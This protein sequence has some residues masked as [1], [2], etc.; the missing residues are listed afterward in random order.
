MIQQYQNQLTNIS[1]KIRFIQLVIQ[2]KINIKSSKDHILRQAASEGLGSD[3]VEQFLKMSILSLS[4]ERVEELMRQQTI[5]E[6]Q[7]AATQAETS[8]QRYERDLLKLIG[9][10]KRKR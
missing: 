10:K 2:D 3:A 1:N 4:K 5:T 9:S 6:G 8:S 7:L